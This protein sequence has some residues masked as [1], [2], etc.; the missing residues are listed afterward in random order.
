MEK[1]DLT[2]VKATIL[3]VFV[4]FGVAMK[5]VF[6]ERSQRNAFTSGAVTHENV[7]KF[8]ESHG[9]NNIQAYTRFN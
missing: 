1:G 4:G 9:V 6:T 2:N 7:L 8:L 3:R 5:V